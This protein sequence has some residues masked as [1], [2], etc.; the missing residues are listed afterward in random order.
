MNLIKPVL[1]A[2]TTFDLSPTGDLNRIGKLTLPNML[3]TLFSVLLVVVGIV[4]LFMLIMGGLKWMMSEGDD[5]KLT[6]A[7]NQ[8]TNALVGLVIVFAAWALVALIN[9]I[10]GVNLLN[11]TIKPIAI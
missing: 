8:V 6:A 9:S 3:S 2:D 7:R 4:F 10:F 11:F 5:K 1:A